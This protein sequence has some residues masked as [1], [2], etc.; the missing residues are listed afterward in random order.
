M[1]TILRISGGHDHSHT[2]EKEPQQEDVTKNQHMY[3]LETV[4]VL[5]HIGET[6][7]V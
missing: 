5:T 2:P 7:C 4:C 3:N 1:G 6:R